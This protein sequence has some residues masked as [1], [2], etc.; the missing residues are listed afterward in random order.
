VKEA[1]IISAPKDYPD[2]DILDISE[3]LPNDLSL[4]RQN[5]ENKLFAGIE[6][7]MPT[8]I[9]VYL[10]KPFFEA[11]LKK[12]GEDA[13]ELT[14]SRLKKFIIKN[15]RIKVKRV[16][17]S[18]S[19]DK[20]N[21]SYDQSLAISLKARLQPRIIVTVLISETVPEND[22]EDSLEGMLNLLFLL[23]DNI[24]NN[25][26]EFH[27]DSKPTQLYLVANVEE[28]KWELLTEIQMAHKYNVIQ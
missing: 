6:W 16:A 1:V 14:K 5:F 2:Q 28:K 12:F 25:P 26:Q 10:L 17:A 15:R 3:A 18:K 13:Y 11:F 27:G 21:K 20:L 23:Y 24:Q 7:A 4:T 22:L 19:P 9:V 8:I